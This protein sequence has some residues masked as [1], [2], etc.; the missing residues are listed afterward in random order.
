MILYRLGND[1]G[2]FPNIDHWAANGMGFEGSDDLGVGSTGVL[3]PRRRVEY[4][5]LKASPESM[6]D[7]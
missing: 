1:F 7:A 6:G 5:A 4:H 2:N 3:Q